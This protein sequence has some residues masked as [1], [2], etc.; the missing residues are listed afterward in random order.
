MVM[1]LVAVVVYEKFDVMILKCARFNVDLLWAGPSWRRASS[2]CSSEVCLRRRCREAHP[3]AKKVPMRAPRRMRGRERRRVGLERL[4]L[5]K[6][7]VGLQI[8]HLLSERLRRYET[9]LEDTTIRVS[10]TGKQWYSERC[11]WQAVGCL[12]ARRTACSSWPPRSRR[13]IWRFG[14]FTW[15]RCRC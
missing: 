6:P 11:R 14:A 12:C 13:G 7:E 3:S 8:S 5:D 1:G 9:R 10:Q 15:S 2:R 4:M